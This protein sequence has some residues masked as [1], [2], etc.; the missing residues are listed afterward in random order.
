LIRFSFGP[1]CEES[2]VKRP[3]D[4]RGVFSSESIL[5]SWLELIG[6]WDLLLFLRIRW[7]PGLTG[8]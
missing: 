3:G 4:R 7:L 6:N 5:S 8:I 1:Q 2:K